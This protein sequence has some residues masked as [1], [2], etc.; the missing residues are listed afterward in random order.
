M[1]WLSKAKLI[2]HPWRQFTQHACLHYPEP[3]CK[4]SP[5]TSLWG[6]TPH[7]FIAAFNSNSPFWVLAPGPFFWVWLLTKGKDAEKKEKSPVGC[8]HGLN[9]I[10]RIPLPVPMTGWQL[11]FNECVLSNSW[12]FPCFFSIPFL[13]KRRERERS[14]GV[15]IQ[16]PM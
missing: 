3:D 15:D 10:P 2:F 5:F 13:L 6:R 12:F 7:G 16:I 8:L 4:F 9:N 11:S 1:T 14:L